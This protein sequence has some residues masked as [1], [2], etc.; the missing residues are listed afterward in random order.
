[1]AHKILTIPLM[2]C[3][4]PDVSSCPIVPAIV[5]SSCGLCHYRSLAKGSSRESHIC[6]AKRGGGGGV[7]HI[8]N[9]STL[10]L[11]APTFIL[12]SLS[13]ASFVAS[14]KQHIVLVSPCIV[15]NWPGWS[16]GVA[17]YDLDRHCWLLRASR[18]TWRSDFLLNCGCSIRLTEFDVGI[19]LILSVICPL[20]SWNTVHDLTIVSPVNDVITVSR[21][22]GTCRSILECDSVR[23]LCPE[24]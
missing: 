21:Y 2:C 9:L 12:I 8:I 23:R 7:Y 10:I 15:S 3:H 14:L 4:S 11:F 16:A 5:L 18:S 6:W 17:A 24:K 22:L 13:Q 20:F 1:M 19:N